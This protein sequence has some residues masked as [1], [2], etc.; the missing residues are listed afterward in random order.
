MIEQVPLSNWD[1]VKVTALCRSPCAKDLLVTLFFSS[2]LKKKK[3]I[4]LKV[5]RVQILQSN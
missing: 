1:F 3:N 2:Q 4:I 5:N